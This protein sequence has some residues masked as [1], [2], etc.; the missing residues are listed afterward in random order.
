MMTRVPSMILVLMGVAYPVFRIARM[1]IPVRLIP[2]RTLE[3]RLFAPT[4][5][6]ADDFY[7]RKSE[8][9]GIMQMKSEVLLSKDVAYLLDCSPDEVVDL[10]RRGRL[11]AVKQGKFWRFYRSDVMVYKRLQKKANERLAKI[12]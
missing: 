5:L 11:P 6:F 2:V 10:A 12:A 1:E 9:E 4:Y 8:V 7:A 3:A